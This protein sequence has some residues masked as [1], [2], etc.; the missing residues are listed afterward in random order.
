[1]DF[2]PIK[3]Q[4]NIENY[5]SKNL[6]FQVEIVQS[7][8]LTKSTREAPWKLV[9]ENNGKVTSFVLQ[10]D[11]DTMEHEYQSLKAMERIPIPTPKAYG[12][13]LS[14][15]GIGVPCFFSD[16][17]EGESLLEPMLAGELWAEE[18]YLNT[19]S[20]LQSVTEK[21]L[22]KFAKIL[23]YETA[24]DVLEDTYSDLKTETRSLADVAYRNL[25]RTMPEIPTV[26]FSNG[27]L[28]LENFIVKDRKL[29]GVIDFANA[30]FS[31]P[32]FEFLLSF[33]VAPELQ[34]RGIEIRYCQQMGYDPSMLHWYHGLEYFDTW[35]WVLKTGEGFVHHTAESLEIDLRNWLGDE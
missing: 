18:L 5:L 24:E 15:K 28:W 25:K 1:M 21:E 16:F 19:V 9:V 23:D 10:L 2:D 6:G 13:D 30:T 32:I 22:G 11:Q 31:D 29:A 20:E 7:T 3:N 8:K 17:I 4:K 35:R 33:F 34:G 27:D 26:R 12:L 14:G